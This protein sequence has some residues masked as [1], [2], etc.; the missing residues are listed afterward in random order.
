MNKSLLLSVIV[1][2][3]GA[4]SLSAVCPEYNTYAAQV[5]F[6]TRQQQEAEELSQSAQQQL[7]MGD[8]DP[9][10]RRELMS[11]RQSYTTLLDNIGSSLDN[12]QM[13]LKKC[14]QQ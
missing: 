8:V 10:T 14:L 4:H 9:F 7:S 12:A 1:L 5:T 11:T 13:R 2:L 6:W 3:M